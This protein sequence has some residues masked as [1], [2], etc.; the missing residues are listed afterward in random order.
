[1]DSSSGKPTFS[2]AINDLKDETE[3]DRLKNIKKPEDIS[4]IRDWKDKCREE[5]GP[6]VLKE[7]EDAPGQL[8]ECVLQYVKLDKLQIEVNRSMARG[9][10]DRVF[11]KY[12]G[13]RDDILYCVDTMLTTFQTCMTAQQ[14]VDV[15]VTRR[16]VDAAINFTCHDDGDRIALFMAEQGVECVR[17]HKD[18]IR[19]CIEDRVPSVKTSIDDPD[20]LS[21][22]HIVINEQQC[23][24]LNAMHSCVVQEAEK[25]SDPTP[26]NILDA[27]IVQ[28]LKVTPCWGFRAAE[29]SAAKEVKDA[30]SGAESLG[31]LVRS[32]ISNIGPIFT[33]G[34]SSMSYVSGLV[35]AVGF[36]VSAL[37]TQVYYAISFAV[38]TL[39]DIF[40]AAIDNVTGALTSI[41]I[42][43]SSSCTVVSGILQGIP[44]LLSDALKK[45]SYFKN[46]VIDAQSIL[47]SY[48][49]EHI[50]EV[51]EKTW[52]LF[53]T[54]VSIPGAL[55]VVMAALTA[56]HLVL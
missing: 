5:H 9:N 25:C 43:L 3:L 16:A 13:Y 48:L 28:M 45:E 44:N 31:R 39:F 40:S 32:S 21:L 11:K 10:L 36:I 6:A 27:L 49:G 26:A 46:Y 56:A 35:G 24:K 1:M 30:S 41:I 7:I 54:N 22:D 37:S 55:V 8:M 47:S 23:E 14:L 34:F 29:Q 50:K 17:E 51:F 53:S 19:T 15:N 2:S 18:G 12:C 20:S 42:G 4:Q 33:S 38:Y 52:I